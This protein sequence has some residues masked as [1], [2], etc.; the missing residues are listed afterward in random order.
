MSKQYIRGIEQAE[1][2]RQ[3]LTSLEEFHPKKWDTKVRIVDEIATPLINWA[4]VMRM[5]VQLQALNQIKLRKRLLH[6]DDEQFKI[7][8]KLGGIDAN[9]QDLLFTADCI[10]LLEDNYWG[11]EL[12]LRGKADD[13]WRNYYVYEAKPRFPRHGGVMIMILSTDCIENH[14]T[15]FVGPV[16]KRELSRLRGLLTATV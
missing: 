8:N 12:R 11:R 4:E 9:N 2:T 1:L 10:K 16:T 15:Y 3:F 13:Q 6:V 5:S 7:L 14:P